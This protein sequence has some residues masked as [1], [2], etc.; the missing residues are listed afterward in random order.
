MVASAH[1]RGPD[2]RH[3]VD[4]VSTHSAPWLAWS[5]CALSLALT[6]LG[7]LLLVLGSFPPGA[8][9]FDYWIE[10]T[11]SGVSS[12]PGGA[13]RPPRRSEHPVGWLFCTIGLL[14][15]VDHFC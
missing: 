10:T 3:R 12:P 9:I 14:A 1:N 13:I 6:A 5:M 15:A 7:L 11:A 8:N 4:R 2:R